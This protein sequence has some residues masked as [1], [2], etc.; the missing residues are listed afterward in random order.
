M[1]TIWTGSSEGSTYVM[2]ID[3]V[4]NSF[5]LDAKPDSPLSF[6]DGGYFINYGFL[7]IADEN[8]RNFFIQ[9]FGAQEYK[10]MICA[11]KAY[12]KFPCQENETEEYRTKRELFFMNAFEEIK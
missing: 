11:G 7:S 12:D 1:D 2:R 9:N 6:V 8:N 4:K 10:E 5:E 3:K